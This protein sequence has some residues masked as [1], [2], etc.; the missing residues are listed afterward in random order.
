[1]GT[2]TSYTYDQY[3]NVIETLHQF[4]ENGSWIS[5]SKS[6]NVYYPNTTL[7]ILALPA[8]QYTYSCSSG[9]TCSALQAA[10]Y[11]YYDGKNDYTIP[12]VKGSVTRARTWIDGSNYAQSDFT[13]DGYGNQTSATSYTGYGTLTSSPD[14]GTAQTTTTTYESTLHLF[15]ATTTN[16]MGHVT[17]LAYNY[18]FSSPSAMTDP[19]GA[20][21]SVTYD[22]FGRINALY[23]PLDALP[24]IAI[25]Y[26]DA[27]PF[28]TTLTQHVDMIGS[29]QKY[30]TVTRKYDGMGRQKQMISGGTITDTLYVSP[31]E[32][33]SSTP[34]QGSETK[35]YTKATT[36]VLGRT[37]TITAPDNTT[38]TYAYDDQQTQ[39][40]DA[41]GHITTTNTDLRGRT[42]SVQPPAGPSV[43]FT[44]DDMDRLL[45][46][47]RGG[48]V[49][50]FGYDQSGRKISMDDPDLG[51]WS[52]SYN[53]LGNML[54]QTDARSCTLTMTYDVLNRP[55]GKASSG[56]GCGTQVNASYAYDQGTYGIGRRTSMADDSGSTTWT[57]DLRGRM[58]SESKTIGAQNFLTSTSYNFAD[59]PTSMVYPDGEGV[60]FEYNDQK[61]FEQLWNMQGNYAQDTEYDPAGRMTSRV[62]G[63]GLT[64]KYKYFAW[65]TQ[66]GRLDKM[67]IGSGA[68]ND[69]A[70]TFAN[71]LQKM[72]YTYDNVGNI[73]TIVDPLANETQTFTYDNLDRL[74]N[75]NV[76]NGPAPYS[77]SY[78]YDPATG[79]ISNKSGV[80]YT[81][82]VN[83]KH[84]VASLSN[85]N[86]YA[87]D[88]NGNM[89]TRH[90]ANGLD[91]GD[92]TFNYNAENQLVE[93]I[94]NN[95]SIAAFTYDGD[96]KRVKSESDGETT[97]FVGAHYEKIVGGAETKYY[98]AGAERVAVR[99]A[100]VLTYLAGDHLGSAS[101]VTDAN[102]ALITKTLYKAWGEVRYATPT[103]TLSTRYTYTGQY[104]Y[105]SDDATDMGNNGFGL[106]YYNAR[107]YDPYINHFAQADTIVPGAG[108]SQAWDRYAYTMNNPLRYIDPSGHEPVCVYIENGEC[109]EYQDP[110]VEVQAL[111]DQE[112][113]QAA[114]ATAIF[115]YAIDVNGATLLVGG[116]YADGETKLNKYTGEITVNIG[117]TS[118]EEGSAVLVSTLIHESVHVTQL[119]EGR[120]SDTDP[121]YALNEVEAYDT[122]IAVAKRLGLNLTPDQKNEVEKTRQ[123]E[124]ALLTPVFQTMVNNG[125][126]YQY[127]IWMSQ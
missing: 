101:L 69:T 100:G 5:Y 70:F 113:Y 63:N 46:S 77:E 119:Q 71:T 36:D 42:T 123:T 21:T 67:V 4:L 57:Y 83:H 104:S 17:T 126:Y 14:S 6:M 10:N 35:Y 40:T 60:N 95:V 44:Y 59:M 11:I 91:T 58:T 108:S 2:K 94:K 127:G 90:V 28:T 33:W 87:Y 84:A 1:L 78:G 79:S 89:I 18:T 27:Y 16:A 124:F 32:T 47:T 65:N 115:L 111:I 118:F 102:G 81:Y 88:A 99:K 105:I 8:E 25:T 52:Y 23:R 19:N 103:T 20:V 92:Y 7:N 114:I 54:T 72:T 93:V 97:L 82:D 120:K 125:H 107:W 110:E 61:L 29:T 56:T 73:Q 34:Y 37:K 64:Q 26:A 39:V 62:L 22:T 48:A 49:V 24:A 74:T 9:G 122:E 12:P 66:G 109:G 31:N 68:W 3:D 41:L 75:A 50:T 30:Y 38:T 116:T 15:P 121:G 96:G 117:K 85:G 106:M 45:T 43:N 86:T 112:N 55:T 98:F 80:T 76:T 51:V 53:A 13:Y